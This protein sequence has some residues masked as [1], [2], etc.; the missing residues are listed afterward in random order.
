MLSCMMVREVG[1][2]IGIPHF[3]LTLSQLT[4]DAGPRYVFVQPLHALLRVAVGLGQVRKQTGT[5]CFLCRSVLVNKPFK[6][7]WLSDLPTS[8]TFTRFT[9]C[10]YSVIM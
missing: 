1:G 3:R 4:Y 6:A 7:Y 2:F 10:P 8:L 9:F 5:A